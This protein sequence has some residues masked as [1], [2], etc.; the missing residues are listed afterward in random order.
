MLSFDS[1]RGTVDPILLS[2]YEEESVHNPAENLLPI[3]L[4][5]VSCSDPMYKQ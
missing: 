1:F 3:S 5:I 4:I 2:S